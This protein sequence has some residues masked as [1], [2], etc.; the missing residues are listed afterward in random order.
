MFLFTY[1]LMCAGEKGIYGVDEDEVY[2]MNVEPYS[3]RLA[4]DINN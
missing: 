2:S 3:H 4:K 1:E